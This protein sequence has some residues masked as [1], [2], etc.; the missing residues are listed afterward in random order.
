M[1]KRK[2]KLSMK[3]AKFMTIMFG[4]A[5][6]LFGILTGILVPLIAGVAFGV[7]AYFISLHTEI[8][9]EYLYVDRQLTV[10]KVLNRAKRK[11]V[12]TYDLERM[13]ILAPMKS[14]HLD[15]YKNRDAKVENYSSG[16]ENQPETR[17]VMFYDGKTKVIFEPNPEMVKA[18]AMI[19]PRKV[20]KD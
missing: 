2:A 18:I 15:S 4:A 17:Y 9:Y 10:D 11:K 7:A 1:V 12:A 19:A 20:F 16:I 5:F 8:E 14:Y 3:L 6:F 13:E